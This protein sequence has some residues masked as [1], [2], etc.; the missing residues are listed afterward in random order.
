MSSGTDK[1]RMAVLCERLEH[2]RMWLQGEMREGD[3]NEVTN[4]VLRTP[5]VDFFAVL[6]GDLARSRGLRFDSYMYAMSEVPHKYAEKSFTSTYRGAEALM[7][8]RACML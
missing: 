2:W 8:I 1:P 7:L 3:T 6:R 4:L 5:E